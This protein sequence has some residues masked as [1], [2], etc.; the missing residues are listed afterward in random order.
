MNVCNWS[1][2]QYGGHS[3]E[4]PSRARRTLNARDGSLLLT[5]DVRPPEAEV[6]SER[7][8]SSLTGRRLIPDVHAREMMALAG[9]AIRSALPAKAVCALR[10]FGSGSDAA[11]LLVRGLP[12]QE[13]V[14]PTPV[15]GVGAE[16]ETA[17]ADMLLL[18]VYDVMRVDPVA[19]EF[20]NQ[21]RLFRNVVPNPNAKGQKSSHGFDADLGWHT[22]NPCGPFEGDDDDRGR[23][24]VPRFLGFS[25][26]RNRD[27][28]DAPVPTEVLP[29]DPVLKTLESEVLDALGLPEFRVDPPASNCLESLVWVPL[30]SR[31]DDGSIF[32]RFNAEQV[33]GLTDRADGALEA[34][35]AA[36]HLSEPQVL[37]YDLDRSMCLVFDNYRVFHRRR[38][39]D[40]GPDPSHARWLRRCY[41]CRSLLN[42]SFVDRVHCPN[43]WV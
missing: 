36:L 43:L 23:S 41:A 31:R 30:V 26:L 6:L 24:P 2:R 34:F 39:F 27:A 7:L 40:P 37:N 16:Y 9:E 5:V 32:V 10:C 13:S 17:F 14:P 19:F 11:A 25:P 22:D 21:G 29:V 28:N 20:E 18:G 1:S 4:R 8:R 15:Y 3:K 12:I 35:K 42:G 38:A 33:H